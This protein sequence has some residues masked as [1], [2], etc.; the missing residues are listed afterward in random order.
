M[1]MPTALRSLDD[2]VLGD[3]LK[4]GDDQHAGGQVT[5]PYPD[6]PRTRVVERVERPEPG[7]N[8]DGPREVLSVVCRVS[9]V[10]LLGLAAVVA[11]GVLFVLAPTNP[12]NGLVSTVADVARWAA[13]PFRDVFTV[14]DDAERELVVNYGFA[15]AVYVVGALLV[16]RL[17]RTAR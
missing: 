9:K 7:G 17:G 2:R 6:E 3:R 8:G 11:L 1:R 15:A 12:D 4:G 16:G 13:G 14:A 5:E 10:V